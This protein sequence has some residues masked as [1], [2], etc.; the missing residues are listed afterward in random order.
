LKPPLEIKK[1]SPDLP[2]G[3]DGNEKASS[4]RGKQNYTF[5]DGWQELVSMMMD[6]VSDLGFSTHG[7]DYTQV[8]KKVKCQ[9]Q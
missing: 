4:S 9:Q 5:P 8:L 2:G 6:V 3:L 7:Q 1:P